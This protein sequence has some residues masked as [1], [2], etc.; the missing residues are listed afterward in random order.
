[1]DTF[2]RKN[3]KH[4][5]I[6]FA[7]GN[8]HKLHE[9]S[10]ILGENFHLL[11]P[12][13]KGIAEEIPETGSTLKDNSLQ[14]AQYIF[15]HTG[16]ADCF[17]DDTGLEVDVLGGA[18]GVYSARYAGESKDF[19]ANSDKLLREM[20]LKEFEASVAREFGIRSAHTDRKARFRTVVTLILGGEKHFF[21]G[22]MEGRIAC[23]KTGSGGFGYD[24]VFIADEYPDV[25]VAELTEEQKNAISH[26][27]KALAAMAE[28]LKGLKA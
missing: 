24:P 6:I 19:N 22:V 12:A 27:G 2:A 16:G 21:E 7:T 5:D 15:D 25:S 9:A 1:M 26:R 23:S 13:D 18:P 11:T 14:K 4:M 28:F 17:A 20:A 3:K 8:P 10:E